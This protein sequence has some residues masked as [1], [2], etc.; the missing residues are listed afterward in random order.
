MQSCAQYVEYQLPTEHTRVGYLLAGI[1]CNDAGLQAA[2][3]SVKLDTAPIT[4]KR[5]DFEA[6]ASHLLPYD[7]VAKKRTS[8]HKR[9]SGEISEITGEISSFGAKEGIGH[10]GVHLRYHKPEEYAT[11]SK[12]QTDELRAWRITPDGKQKSKRGK[13]KEKGHKKGSEFKRVKQAM[14]ASVNKQVK[15]RL[16][17]IEQQKS[18]AVTFESPSR[19]DARAYIM[20]LLE[21][22]R[23][24]AP[25]A[26]PKQR[27]TLKSIL[28]KSKNANI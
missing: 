9:G 24:A 1:Q 19:D 18:A 23:P 14:A 3:A 16:A 11:L 15:K 13:G 28:A 27:V 20:S 25:D 22:P 4:G 6:A 7:P 5:N 2:M 10:T 17:E 8:G 26:P 21:E 12:E